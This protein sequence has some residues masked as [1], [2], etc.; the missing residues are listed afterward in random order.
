MKRRMDLRPL[1][2]RPFELDIYLSNQHRM[3]AWTPP[4]HWLS[5]SRDAYKRSMEFLQGIVT[6]SPHM[7]LK[8]NVQSLPKITVQ[9]TSRR[10]YSINTRA[11]YIEDYIEVEGDYREVK[12]VHWNISILGAAWKTD[13]DHETPFAV[14]LCINPRSES[15][16]LPV[17]DQVA[18]LALALRNDKTTAMR[19]PL[20]A[21]FIV[22]PRNALRG[23]YQFSEEGVVMEDDVFMEPPDEFE[24]EDLDEYADIPQDWPSVGVFEPFEFEHF[25]S[26]IEDRQLDSWM[27][28]QEERASR[29]SRS[30]WHHD[31]DRIWEME[32]NLRKGRR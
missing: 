23:V 5:A 4:G 27:E 12:E 16:G 18:A 2:L 7:E 30:P 19:I 15:R 20:L 13:L 11:H 6:G 24:I 1:G 17:G 22:S 32:D 10:W 29:S 21:Q 8:E 26:E 25:A 28:K 3:V 14:S 31:E 9:G